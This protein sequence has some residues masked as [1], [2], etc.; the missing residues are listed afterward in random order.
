MNMGGIGRYSEEK[1]SL[2][3]LNAGV[4]IL[5]HPADPDNVVSYLEGKDAGFRVQASGVRQTDT[6]W[7]RKESSICS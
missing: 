4:D 5:L 6:R 2:M 3:A 1:A 7:K